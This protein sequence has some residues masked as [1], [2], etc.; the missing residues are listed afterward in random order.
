MKINTPVTQKEILLGVNDTIVSKTDNKGVITFVN[1]EFVAISGFTEAELIGKSH[2]IVRHPDMPPQAFEDLWTTVKAGNG[3]QG[4][5]KNRCKN[6]DYYWVHAH[7]TPI[8]EGKEIVGYTSVRRCPERKEIEIAESIYATL[9][10]GKHVDLHANEHS[11]LSKMP[12]RVRLSLMLLL[13]ILGL[14]Y[15]SVNSVLEK[16]HRLDELQTTKLITTLAVKSSAVIHEAQKE[17]GLSAGFIS[18][19]GASFTN[20]LPV[21]RGKTDQRILELKELLK[22]LDKSGLDEG[23][24]G[25][26]L[27]A[28]KTLEVLAENRSA[29][30][31]LNRTPKDSFNYY[32]G[33]ISTWLDVISYSAKTS[34]NEKLARSTTAYLMFLT[35]KEMAGRE[36]A[37]VNGA[38]AA[39]KFEW[40][41]FQRFIGLMA[42]QKSYF[43][44]FQSYAP[45]SALDVFRAKLSGATVEQVESYRKIAIDK[46]MTGEFGVK[47]GDWFKAITAKIDAMKEVEDFLSADLF[48]LANNLEQEALHLLELYVAL[49]IAILI[50]TLLLGVWLIR[51]LLQELGGEPSYARSVAN[52][53]ASGDFDVEVKT[54][55][56]DNNSLMASIKNMK[57]TINYMISDGQ[58]TAAEA[59]RVKAALDNSTANVA[60][61]NNEGQIIYLNK[62]IQKMFEENEENIRAVL[63]HFKASAVLGSNFDSFHKNA[64]HQRGLLQSLTG[65]HRAT[66]PIGGLTFKL[67]ALPVTNE[68]GQRLG[69]AVEWIDATQEIKIE[70]EVRDIVVSAQNGDFTKR[71]NLADKEGFMRELSDGI[72]HLVQTSDQGLQ[73]VVRMLGALAQ[74]DLT[75]R[76]TNEYHGTFGKLKDDSNTTVAQLTE[77]IGRIKDA[78]D[79]ISTAA[80]EIASGN[81]DLSQRTEE[82]ASSLEETAAS[83]EELT[84][85]VKQ[86]AENASQANQLAAR[87]SDIARQ[88]G[89]VVGQVVHTMASINESSKKIVDIISVI[90][91]IA[92]QTNILALNAAVE[93]ARAG[94]QGRGFAVVAA[95]VRNLAQRSAGA[96]KE[97]KTLIGDS[98]LKVKFGTELVDKAGHTMNEVVSSVKRVTDIMAEISA[99]SMEQSK[100]IEQVNQAI[101]QMDDVTQQN[102]ALVEQAAAAA[103]SM[104]EQAQELAKLVAT[105]RLEKDAQHTGMAALPRSISKFAKK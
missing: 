23:F 47:P 91:G 61:A 52:A 50:A 85:T 57:D 3:W 67:A 40:D 99:A 73:E 11:V 56:G 14:L 76:I 29:I 82:Q 22:T 19:K 86:N 15:F 100:G 89:E 24:R 13:P 71:L 49:T 94:E 72:N 48:N 38:F 60:I 88:G 10:A 55:L 92:F 102:A 70:S 2:N 7:V 6:G 31:G 12:I 43:D 68:K 34:S 32:T 79:T 87:A 96:A 9:R 104:E 39:D 101:T 8:H 69:T 75:D 93:A 17:R 18:S 51:V 25:T 97:I 4:I 1:P 45:T 105:F 35:G 27:A 74:G 21:Q 46:A 81:T 103:E 58:R 63:P 53:V 28:Q 36:R 84:S 62:A 30:S 20:E 42:N 83:M 98:V 78:T 95:E 16:S 80:Q 5:V 77:V 44:I 54:R 37:T 90:D 65:L 26:L 64:A 41:A 59:L 66:V 33:M